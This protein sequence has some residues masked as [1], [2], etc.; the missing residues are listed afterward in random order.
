[1]AAPVQEFS[2][3]QH[4]VA[5]ALPPVGEI[6]VNPLFS[7]LIP[8]PDDG[9]V[10]VESTKVEGMADHIVLPASHTFMMNNPLVIVQTAIFLRTG[11]FDHTL[12]LRELMRRVTR[13]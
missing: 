8:G 1:V 13:R 5:T 2:A 3:A 10:S 4:G 6:S 12:N 7:S 11:S 9:A